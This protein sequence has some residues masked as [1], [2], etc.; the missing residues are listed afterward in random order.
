LFLSDS[1]YIGYKQNTDALITFGW[2]LNGIGAK[3]I[4]FDSQGAWESY[5][6]KAGSLMIRP[7]FGEYKYVTSLSRESSVVANQIQAYPNPVTDSKLFVKSELEPVLEYYL[8]SI[9]GK[10]LDHQFKKDMESTIEVP[11]NSYEKI[12]V[13]KVITKSTSKVFKLLNNQY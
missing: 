13:L 5:T 1:F 11:I 9:D 4:S 12:L 6:G 7:V 2:D 10:L 8:Y 3:N